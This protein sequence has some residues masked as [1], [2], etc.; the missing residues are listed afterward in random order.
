VKELKIVARLL[1]QERGE[2]VRISRERA[3]PISDHPLVMIPIVMAGE[4]PALFALGI[5]YGSKPCRVH[6][7][8]EPR[9]RDQQYDMLERAASDMQAILGAWERNAALMP[10]VITPSRD[11]SRM[12]LATFHR[13]T[14]APR[15]ALKKVGRQL[16]WLDR[17]FEQ[18]DSAGL[19]NMPAA[20]CELFAT[21]QDDHADSHLGA[22]LEWLKPADGQ[23]YDRIIAAEDKPASTSTHP[24]LDNQELVPAVEALRKAEEAGD[25]ESARRLRAQIE[26]ILRREVECR[27]DLIQRALAV[28]RR[29]R[30]SFAADHVQSR[31]RERHD[32]NL[33]YVSDPDNLLAAGLSGNAATAE[34]L[35]RELNAEHIDQLKV[36]S[37]SAAR[38]SA[39]LSGDILVGRVRNRKEY[40]S[41]RK[42]I[43]TYEVQTGQERLIWNRLRY[44]KD[45]VTGKRVSRANPESDWIIREISELRIVDQE[46]WERAKARQAE[47]RKDTRPDCEQERPFWARTRPRYLLSGL[48]RCGSCGGAYTKI[49]AHLFGCAT[50]RNKGTCSNRLNIRREEIE[51]LVLGGLKGRLMQPEL[52]KVFAEEFAREFNRLRAA[53]GNEI[54]QAKSELAAVERRL[55]K[56]VEAIADGVPARTLKEELL[57]LETRQDELREL[58]ARPEPNRTLIHPG[59][60]EIYRRKVA[61]LH[62]ALEDEATREEAMELMEACFSFGAEAAFHLMGLFAS[63]NDYHGR[64]DE[65]AMWSEVAIRFIPSAYREGC[66]RIVPWFSEKTVTR[67]ELDAANQAKPKL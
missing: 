1:A 52:F 42:T 20:I 61:A 37:V 2:A 9:N 31:D 57:R 4:A 41:G 12:C 56:I 7:C 62:E 66:D 5:G 29:F 43:I 8:V 10:Q 23:I 18:P 3:Y 59:L 22:L 45:P 47:L 58:L 51:K 15:P 14:Y 30:S 49:N 46:L 40:K 63:E 48:M 65:A 35:S 60:A 21:G 32:R 50:A 11:A 55:R 44:V 25:S 34:F 26:E 39:R 17:T 13:M 67:R 24:R 28:C 27:Y 36:R 16:H 53:E 33:A 64:K 6:V 19:L 38:A 54:E